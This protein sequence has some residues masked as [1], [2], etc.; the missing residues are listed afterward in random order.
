MKA[1]KALM[2]AIA[3][4][5]TFG[6]VQAETLTWTGAKGDGRYITAG[7]WDGKKTPTENDEVIL[8]EAAEGQTIVLGVKESGN[9][10]ANGVRAAKLVVK[11]NVTLLH[12]SNVTDPC[13]SYSSKNIPRIAEVSIDEGC[14]LTMKFEVGYGFLADVNGKGTLR[15]ECEDDTSRLI[16][17]NGT[18][19]DTTFDVASGFLRFGTSSGSC[20]TGDTID[21]VTFVLGGT[22]DVVFYDKL[23]VVEGTTVTVVNE[24]DKYMFDGCTQSNS[25]VPTHCDAT[26]DN[27]A[28]LPY[29]NDFTLVKKGAGEL[30]HFLNVDGHTCNCVVN[31]GALV[32]AAYI[33]M[34]IDGTFTGD[35][36]I[37]VAN[38]GTHGDT[39]Y[40]F[41][42]TMKNESKGFNWYGN[43][44]WKVL[45]G[46]DPFGREGATVRYAPNAN[47]DFSPDS[48]TAFW[49]PYYLEFGAGVRLYKN[50]LGGK[51]LG[52][53]L[54]GGVATLNTPQIYKYNNCSY[55][56][57]EENPFVFDLGENTLLVNVAGSAYNQSMSNCVI[58]GSGCFN[59]FSGTININGP[60]TMEG[61]LFQG[62]GG[63]V[64]VSSGILL[65]VHDYSNTKQLQGSQGKDAGTLKVTGTLGAM[66]AL[67]QAG[68]G[69]RIKLELADTAKIQ[70]PATYEIGAAY[71][72]VYKH[73]SPLT[74]PDG[75]GKNVSY[76]LGDTE[77]Q[78]DLEFDIPKCT[79][80]TLA[81]SQSVTWSG[82]VIGS[83]DDPTG[84]DGGSAPSR[85]DEVVLDQPVTLALSEIS[86]G[87]TVSIK[88]DVVLT[89]TPVAGCFSKIVVDEG[90][91]VTFRAPAGET[92]DVGYVIEGAGAVA[93][94][95]G[96]GSAVNF[97]MNNTFTGGLTVRS[98]EA[99]T[100]MTE[101]FG[102][103][104]SD[105]D[106]YDAITAPQIV[107]E[108]GAT[109]RMDKTAEKHYWIESAGTIYASGSN[110]TDS[111]QSFWR[112]SLAGDTLLK[113]K[114]I[115]LLR[116]QYA[117]AQLIL[118]GHTL[119]LDL[120]AGCNF[121]ISNTSMPEDDE[122][123]INVV[124]GSLYDCDRGAESL[125][126]ADVILGAA[127]RL[128]GK[129]SGLM[130]GSL[131]MAEGATFTTSSGN[132]STAPLC[133]LGAVGLTKPWPSDLTL[134]SAADIEFPA[135]WPAGTPLTLC[136]GAL[137]V[138]TVFAEGV[139]VKVGDEV[140]EGG[141]ITVNPDTKSAFYLGPSSELKRTIKG[142]EKWAQDDVWD[143][144]PETGDDVELTI[145]ADAASVEINLDEGL[146]LRNFEV[147]GDAVT[148]KP[149]AAAI[150]VNGTSKIS[151]PV[152]V[153][154]GALDLSLASVEIGDG[155]SLTY[156]L[157]DFAG[158]AI[159]GETAL[160]GACTGGNVNLV[161]PQ[162][163][164]G[165]KVALRAGDDG[166][167][168]LSVT[169][170]REPGELTWVGGSV[171]SGSTELKDAAGNAAYFI[172]PTD[173]IVVK[174][175]ATIKL[176]LP[177]LPDM[178]VAEGGVLKFVETS[179]ALANVR[180]TT[181][182]ITID[183]GGTFDVN[184]N[185]G[186]LT[187]IVLNGGTM[188]N[189][190]DALDFSHNGKFG[191]TDMTLTADSTVDSASIFGTSGENGSW[192]TIDPQGH[193]LTKVGSESYVFRHVKFL[194]DGVIH[195][196]EGELLLPNAIDYD[197]N[198]AIAIRVDE[199]TRINYRDNPRGLTTGTTM[200]LVVNGEMQ[201]YK[202][203]VPVTTLKGHGTIC[204][205]H[206]ST[207]LT[208]KVSDSLQLDE[209]ALT[210]GKMVDLVTADDKP[211]KIRLD[212][213]KNPG[214]VL[215]AKYEP[216]VTRAATLA[217]IMG[218]KLYVGGTEVT[219]DY[220]IVDDKNGCI[221]AKKPLGL[222]LIVR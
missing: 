184:G 21:N 15:L 214:K 179:A 10:D 175:E 215:L 165:R 48:Y 86:F 129:S 222:M 23:H 130:I 57:T 117:P 200:E 134:T 185:N 201:T 195:V 111:N 124:S 218:A 156:D 123:T 167:V 67:A 116:Y 17:F 78:G 88:A 126:G 122:G 113:G 66:T 30:R 166:K 65:T 1:T 137:S 19:K 114:S 81:A 193:T 194:S 178:R 79:V 83:W 158:T 95:G 26:H 176:D 7:N 120:D 108:E 16:L 47:A 212:G 72:L 91:T 73:Y 71:E 206:G 177:F 188:A 205:D 29:D 106:N 9:I 77:L 138:S 38:A 135:D 36:R 55:C 160:V 75:Y 110:S 128:I 172:Y 56:G 144:V 174:D 202:I 58:R 221:Y 159:A 54:I 168:Y 20:V 109:L 209:G 103:I 119:T 46:A 140:I 51:I 63:T 169:A 216:S 213:V 87:G 211:L 74:I 98:G 180:E 34:T 37:G 28:R 220:T 181:P 152:T 105:Y 170:N 49:K 39:T 139:N 45:T 82:D 59:V 183:E 190:G 154:Y 182:T 35:G 61:G 43:R 90:A 107:I 112:L 93:V 141:S 171:L 14:A 42:A 210:F 217:T 64:N 96:D 131:R 84:W 101:G 85:M 40:T 148:F 207:P 197:S 219:A 147:I 99:Y 8:G 153:Q 70:F 44:T 53:K 204:G 145:D 199:G 22:G 41:A 162:T 94:E 151:A 33:A 6:A 161:L 24:T 76:L 104:N 68:N 196:K 155:G 127:G 12:P 102:K 100:A 143:D 32:F 97:N 31:E 27:G 52:V 118:G 18:A 150:A 173:T 25:N 189:T 60:V 146:M 50:T 4:L 164:N 89:G 69:I 186:W 157:T 198:L 80:K 132:D 2:F 62:S 203:A 121:Y 5:A 163:L 208:L 115:T 3:A 11:A 133:V 13:P 149:G 191:Y 92:I 125:T 187:H 192:Q 142:A 136:E